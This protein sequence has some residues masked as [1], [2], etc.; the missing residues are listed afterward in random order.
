MSEPI[1]R[2]EPTRLSVEPGGQAMVTVTV[3]NGGNI[4]E[5]YDVDVVSTM[6]MPW[7]TASPATLS[8]YPQQEAT[9]VITFAPPS[10][11]SAP[12][13]S[14]PFGVRLRSQVD[15]T[16]A[17]VAEGDLDVG[18]VSGLQAALTPV[19]SSGRW[20][21]RHTLR[22]SNWGNAPAR[23][24]I[25]A[26]DAD[27]ALG[28][29]VSP[30][31]L[32]VPLGGEASARIKARTRHPIL[33][34]TAQRL[35]FQVVCEPEAPQELGG[36]RVSSSTPERPVVDGAFNQKPILTRMVV[37]IAGLLLLALIALIVWLI[38]NNGD[39]PEEG[40]ST[41]VVDAPTGV[42]AAALPGI[43]LLTWDADP[44]VGKYEILQ[45]KP[46][47]QDKEV[48]ALYDPQNPNTYLVRL[49]VETA[50]EYCYQLRAL[51]ADGG[52]SKESTPV[53]CVTTVLPPEAT[54]SPSAAPITEAGPKGGEV[55]VPTP[56]PSVS[57]TVD[58]STAVPTESTGPPLRFI[59]VLKVYR[60]FSRSEVPATT[61]A[62]QAQLVAGG[63]TAK[64]L[65]TSAWTITEPLAEPV[66][67]LYVD[68]AESEALT[69][70]C[71]SLR[72]KFPVIS[73]CG[74]AEAREVS[75][76]P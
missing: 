1:L 50:E 45:S 55:P 30:A 24:R 25:V 5:G 60:G 65:H 15:E 56:S 64:V 8:V 34:G 11:A 26:Q 13:G 76:L 33:R 36:P 49:K 31:T 63:V 6:P 52:R 37:A 16:M 46:G 66:W 12:G 58:A 71:E 73:D 40:G 17:A 14:F 10:G 22:V 18:S 43:V 29:M 23:L 28:F 7:A 38:K 39:S 2:M 42:K 75:P 51:R 74:S 59:S 41:K 57:P 35:P 70:A 72:A 3:F 21:G 44:S 4:V 62:D 47:S 61:A 19:T 53:A 20:R 68:A 48:T 27:Q 9:T 67:V 69:G 54:P 32:D